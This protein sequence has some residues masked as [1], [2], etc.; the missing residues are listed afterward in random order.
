MN[1]K[2]WKYK[3]LGD[4]FYTKTRSIFKHRH[5]CLSG[6][7]EILRVKVSRWNCFKYFLPEI[8]T[9]ICGSLQPRV[10]LFLPQ[11]TLVIHSSCVYFF[12]IWSRY[13]WSTFLFAL[14]TL[15]RKKVVEGD[16]GCRI[17]S[18]YVTPWLSQM[19]CLNDIQCGTETNDSRN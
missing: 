5:K 9:L 8:C 1:E 17:C 3:L 12:F 18:R 15:W 4:D 10:L 14:M 7:I 6:T 13:M 11:E 19:T 16:Y 2:M